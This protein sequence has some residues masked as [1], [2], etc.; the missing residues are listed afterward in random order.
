MSYQKK[1]GSSEYYLRSRRVLPT[2]SRA[3]HG[4]GH[5]HGDKYP[6]INRNVDFHKSDKLVAEMAFSQRS[7]RSQAI[8]RV[9]LAEITTNLEAWLHSPNRLDFP[10]VD[11]PNG[12]LIFSH[13]SKRAQAAD[14]AKAAKR[15]VPME[16][17]IKDTAH[18][19]L[20]G[21]DTK[22]AK[23]QGPR[24]KVVR[25]YRV[26]PKE[27]A[28]KLEMKVSESKEA[29][30]KKHTLPSKAEILERAQEIHAE[31]E[32]KSG[33]PAKTAEEGELKESGD[34]E[35]A[36]SELMSGEGSK[37]DAQVLEYVHNINS[38]L[39]PL[40]FKVVEID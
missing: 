24:E 26:V 37:A 15:K 1:H 4:N 36:R 16:I 31:K 11:T 14:L 20:K 39:E 40:G 17:W 33:L 38:E 30:E 10:G 18:T 29:K 6:G 22:N 5:G 35:A 7:K 21:V 34:F 25:K 32:V 3:L 27:E 8:D 28:K 23:T 19:D 13:K 9:K 2:G 12:R